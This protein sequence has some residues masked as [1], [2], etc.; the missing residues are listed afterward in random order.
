M[1]AP[2]LPFNI[3]S[4][5]DLTLKKGEPTDVAFYTHGYSAQIIQVSTDK[6]LAEAS[7]RDRDLYVLKTRTVVQATIARVDYL[8][9]TALHAQVS[10]YAWHLRLGH[11][12]ESRL[13]RLLNSDVPP[14]IG[15]LRAL[16]C[17]CWKPTPRELLKKLSDRA[18]RCYLLGY[19]H[20]PTENLY[21]V[22]NSDRNRVELA[23][24][25][26]FHEDT[27]PKQPL[28]IPITV[29]DNGTL[30]AD[31][32]D[33]GTRK[34]D[35]EHLTSNSA[36]LTYRTLVNTSGS[37]PSNLRLPRDDISLEEALSR[38]QVGS[39]YNS[40]IQNIA[41][42]SS[43]EERQDQA[44]LTLLNQSY[45]YPAE[46]KNYRAAVNSP[47]SKLWAESMAEECKSLTD[48]HTWDLVDAT[49][50]P[51][52]TSPL[53]GKYVYKI[54]TDADGKPV[55][56][57]SRWVVRGFEQEY[58]VD[59]DKTFA[60][61]V[62]PM[63]YKALFVLACSKGWHIEQMDV[64]TAFLYGAIDAEVFVELPPNLRDQHPGKVCHL[65]K[66]LY[67]LKQAP[68][69]WYATL[70]KALQDLGFES[71]LEDY[72]VFGNKQQGIIIAVYVDDLLI[73]CQNQGTIS[74]LKG[75]LS[76]RFQM[77]DL[78]EAAHYLGIKISRKWTK[79]NQHSKLRLSQGA[80]TR[81]VI[82]D[83]DP[84][85][86][87]ANIKP[88]PMDDKL[89]L[90]PNIATAEPQEKRHYQSLIGSL[91]Y[92]MLCTRP[93]IAYAVS[94]LS[95]FAA[96]PSKKHLEAAKRLLRYLKGTSGM[97][98]EI[99]SNSSGG[100]L[101]YTDANW[102]RDSDRRSTGGYVFLLNGTAISWSSKRQATVALSSCE[103]EYIAELEA[104]KE[105][106]WLR[107]LLSSLNLTAKASGP[108]RILGDNEGALAL[109][110]NPMF[111]A[112]TKHL[113]IR[114]HFVREKVEEGLVH[115]E[116]VSGKENLADGLTKPLVKQPF[117]TFR[118]GIGLGRITE[119]VEETLPPTQLPSREGPPPKRQRQLE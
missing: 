77:S 82:R 31:L 39:D 112:R 88:T 24:D 52:R 53:T 36:T 32:N 113:D 106:I 66:A 48:N 107:G 63:S 12:K 111:H 47:Q 64:K 85:L 115:M 109:A 18:E 96:N 118:Y 23:R 46:P 94:Q 114:Y 50:L 76:S 26:L 60:S 30:V 73:F 43:I 84:E 34:L 104:A 105:A 71:L 13:R 28:P 20:R 3:I 108:V 80:Y 29:Y 14:P 22:W 55:R 44:W 10:L 69:I 35:G 93:D 41:L 16:G 86:T 91:M 8:N 117:E 11:L 83:F 45:P 21:R 1:F 56:Y 49:S 42:L 62:K 89:V 40:M 75:E 7:C 57:K 116:W 90:E 4:Q 102:G 59:F 92:L 51:R 79:G 68:R 78:G 98:L 33:K 5:R 6:L 17:E 27:Y 9:L 37:V 87:N 110:K 25:L 61:V 97:G 38:M 103:A 81:R 58:G 99:D 54:K 19:P 72:S 67:G 101:G 95:R 100:L 65:R 15:H 119:E 74:Q 70:K 2:S